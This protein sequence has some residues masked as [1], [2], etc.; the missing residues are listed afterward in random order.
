ML[1]HTLLSTLTAAVLLLG[2]SFHPSIASNQLQQLTIITFH[3]SASAAGAPHIGRDLMKCVC[4]TGPNQNSYDGQSTQRA[5]AKVKGTIYDKDL[6][7][8]S[9]AIKADRTRAAVEWSQY[10]TH[11]WSECCNIQGKETKVGCTPVRPK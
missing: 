6:G 4:Y 9:I 2:Y 10:C 7:Q 11:T 5:C 8:C 1:S 3:S